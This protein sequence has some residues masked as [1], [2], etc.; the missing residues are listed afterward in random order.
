MAYTNSPLVSYKN[1]T[2]HRNSPRNH[3]IDTITIHCYVGQVTVKTGV[4][5]FVTTS[6]QVSSNYVI[7]KDGKIG[8]SVP[9]CDRA[10]T[11]SNGTNDHRAIT[12][13]CACDL[14]APYAL[15]DAA[16]KS[17]IEL[18]TDICKRNGIKK[19]VWSNNSSDR[20]NHRNG[21][22]MTVHRD[23]AS[24]DCPGTFLYSRMGEIASKVN[25]KLN[26]TPTAP[27]TTTTTATQTS[28]GF[29][30][31]KG[32]WQRGDTHDNIGKMA[33]FMRKTFPSY[34]PEAALGNY[35]GQNI[36]KAIKEFQ[37]RTGLE[38]DG[39]VGPDTYKKLKA[40]GFKG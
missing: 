38:A 14:K 3:A 5:Y 16:Y 8:L 21:C 29:L 35:Y 4:D 32:Y 11:S 33:T 37:K 6:R 23:F 25:A 19:L 10:W 28:P 22:N 18:V 30:P 12:I 40:Y 15:T 20:V 39:C 34:T 31:K 24:T 2:S 1:I 7:G 26:P 13:E 27:K 17:L 36:E 9:E